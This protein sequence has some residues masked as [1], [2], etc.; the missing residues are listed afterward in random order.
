[1]TLPPANWYPNPADPAQ[2]R[3]W[4]GQKWTDTVKPEVSPTVTQDK[5]AAALARKEAK[6]AAH[7]TKVAVRTQK[8]EAADYAKALAEWQP[9]RD[10]QAD[11]V[12]LAN[13]FT[14]ETDTSVIL[15]AGEF[16][17]AIVRN[18]SLI[19]D[20]PGQGQFVGHSQ[21]FSIPVGSIGGHSVR[22]RVG[23][24]NGHSVAAPSVATAIDQGTAYVTNQRFI[25]EGAKQTRE[26]LFTKLVSTHSDP[27]G[28]TVFSTSNRQK[29][30]TIS[31]G[32]ALA[33]WF[34][35]RLDLAL[36][37]FRNTVPALVAQ[38]TADLATIDAEKPIEPTQ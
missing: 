18:A 30:T 29:P 22:Y 33:G 4:D 14:G 11:L 16:V 26:C 27:G 7:A 25:F 5:H 37:H 6:H 1:M 10:A 9:R 17:F 13:S 12:E 28:S 19:E 38:V 20:R 3:W 34:E 32:P 8:H 31:Y 23:A 35:F 24:M 21:G 2:V 36:A 15:K